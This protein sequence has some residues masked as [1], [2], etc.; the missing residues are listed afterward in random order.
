M[1]VLTFLND[2][3]AKLLVVVFV[4]GDGSVCLFEVRLSTSE[5]MDG[6]WL[7]LGSAV[8]V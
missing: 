7:S 5:M 8:V 6:L 1:G 2:L 3:S 4:V